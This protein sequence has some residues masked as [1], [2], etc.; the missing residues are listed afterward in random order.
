[1]GAPEGEGV[2]S[3]GRGGWAG[4]GPRRTCFAQVGGRRSHRDAVG[5]GVGLRREAGLEGRVALTGAQGPLTPGRAVFVCSGC[6]NETPQTGGLEAPAVSLSQGSAG[7]QLAVRGP[8][9]RALCLVRSASW[10]INR[11][12]V[13]VA[14]TQWEGEGAAGVPRVRALTP[15]MRAPPSQPNRLLRT[16]LLTPSCWVRI[17]KHEFGADTN[18][19]T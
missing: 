12:L 7:W 9:R 17:S 6:C 11:C 1:M 19:Q 2:N 14:P 4:S 8:A 18:I 10:F 13:A 3:A 5:S 16:P 15:F